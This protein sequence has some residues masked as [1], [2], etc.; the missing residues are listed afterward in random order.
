MKRTFV[1]TFAVLVAA[2]MASMVSAA[3]TPYPALNLSYS[4]PGSTEIAST[5]GLLPLDAA[6]GVFTDP[7]QGSAQSSATRYYGGVIRH[8]LGAGMSGWGGEFLL[9]FIRS[10]GSRVIDI[11]KR[12]GSDNMTFAAQNLSTL[13]AGPLGVDLPFVIKLSDA[14]WNLQNIA[15]F[16][17]A[18]ATSETEGTPDFVANDAFLDLSPPKSIASLRVTFSAA[19]WAPQASSGELSG[20]FSSTAWS[21]AVIPEPAM[22]GVLAPLA[23]LLLRRR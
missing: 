4:A 19:G 23:A 6:T 12:G 21:P 16:I 2:S 14:N 1:T 11:G 15:I 7:D 18:N 17:G 22:M 9:E 3:L 10:D 13:N 5:T 20:V 8:T